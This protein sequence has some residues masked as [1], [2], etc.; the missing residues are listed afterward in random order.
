MQKSMIRLLS[1]ADY[2]T[3][4]NLV[5]GF[6]SIIM[7]LMNEMRFA[8]TFIFLALMA[9]GLDGI[10]ARKTRQ[11]KVGGHLE[12]EADVVSSSVAPAV[13]IYMIYQSIGFE[14][15]YY[16]IFLIAF[17][18]LFLFATST[19]LGCFHVLESRE[20][21][22]GLP[23]PASAIIL[24]LLSLLEVDLIF[25]L[26]ALFIISIAMISSIKFPKPG[27][28]LDGVTGILIILTI[29][30]WKSYFSIAPVIMLA[31]ILIYA[32]GG[33]LYLLKSKE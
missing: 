9:D 1:A 23:A 13:F 17:L 20:N 4:T 30:L 5:F 2:V 12:A 22:V 25:L 18:A 11:S 8:F 32:I 19:R 7:A 10:V 6:F 3:I 27:V 33:P 14:N 16:K 26:L 31:S 24:L 21:F 29:I 28:K 15:I